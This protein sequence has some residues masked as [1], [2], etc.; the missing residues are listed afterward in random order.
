MNESTCL[1]IGVKSRGFTG[2]RVVSETHKKILSELFDKHLEIIEV[3]PGYE[4]F[5]SKMVDLFN[6]YM[7]GLNKKIE[8]DILKRVREYK[9]TYVFIDQSTLGKIIPKIKAISPDICVITFFHNVE[10]HFFKERLKKEPFIFPLMHK[11]WK[12][13]YLAVKYSDK[14]ITLNSRDTAM[15]FDLYGRRSDFILPLCLEDKYQKTTLSDRNHKTVPQGLFVGSLFF[16]NYRGVKWFITHVAPF[17]NAEITVVGKDFETKRDELSVCPNVKIIGSVS[18]LVPYYN[19]ADFII[20]PIFDGSG[21]KTKTAEALMYGKLIYGSPEAFM[22]YDIDFARVGAIC[23]TADEFISAIN[24]FEL[25]S[26]KSYFNPYSREVFCQKYEYQ[27]L[28]REFS[29]V[30]ENT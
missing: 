16:A 21:M 13:E 3:M 1:Y 27:I 19:E 9:P 14:L 26:L 4:P 18:D 6:F 24:S 22:G 17:I 30:F 11:V 7:S 23:K 10:W 25:N 2:G 12:N 29:K 15:L 5:L 28:K 20:S 8:N